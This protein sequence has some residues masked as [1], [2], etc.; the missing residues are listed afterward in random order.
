MLFQ[1]EQRNL[2]PEIIYNEDGTINPN[3]VTQHATEIENGRSR[4]DRLSLDEE[5]GRTRGG[6]RNVEASIITGASERTS[7]PAES[8]AK[9]IT[10][11][12]DYSKRT[13]KWI[14]NNSRNCAS[15]IGRIIFSTI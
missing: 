14:E 9:Q 2:P 10:D 15:N 5:Q 1:E 3:R 13:G 12:T 11:V 4:I 6:R 7:S 8:A